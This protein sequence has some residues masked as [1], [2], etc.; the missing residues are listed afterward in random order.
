MKYTSHHILMLT[1]LLLL[2]SLLTTVAHAENYVSGEVIGR[3]TRENSP[4]N[5]TGEINVPDG[6]ELVIEPGVMVRSHRGDPLVVYG[7]LVAIG[8]EQDS[9]HF[10]P[11]GWLPYWGGVRFIEADSGS[12]LSYCVLR[13]GQRNHGAM[14]DTLVSGGNAMLW[15]TD[16]TI[17]HSSFFDGEAGFSGG[18]LAIYGGAAT[19]SNCLFQGNSGYVGG[20]ISCFDSC[21]AIFDSCDF[22]GNTAIWGGGGGF[23]T[24]SST[25]EFSEC[26]WENNAVAP[27]GEGSFGGALFIYNN[28]DPMI[29][30]CS[31]TGNSASRGGAVY[32]RGFGCA[33]RFFWTDFSGNTA[34]EPIGSGGA[35]CVSGGAPVQINYCRFLFNRAFMGGGLYLSDQP[36][37]IVNNALFKTNVATAS[38]GAIC[39]LGNF[40]EYIWEIDRCTFAGNI[41]LAEDV[42]AFHAIQTLS[43]ASISL[44]SC[45]VTG[46]TPFFDPHSTE[47]S[48]CLVRG[49]AEGEGNLD[50]DPMYFDHDVSWCMIQSESPCVD[51]GDASLPNDTDGTRADIGW[52]S[53]PQNALSGVATDTVTVEMIT[54]EEQRI[55]VRVRNRTGIPV[56]ASLKDAMPFELGETVNVSAIT[57]DEE[58]HGAV[59]CDD[60][61]YIS[62]AGNGMNPTIYHL[63]RDF[64][65]VG[66]FTPP[67]N[68]GESGF[69]DLASDGREVLWGGDIDHIVE[70][71]TSGE[72]GEAF[73]CPEGLFDCRALAMDELFSERFTDFYAGDISGTIV[74]CGDDFRTVDSVNVDMN[75]SALAMRRNARSLYAIGENDGRMELVAVVPASGSISQ[76]ASVELA[77]GYLPGGCEVAR[78]LSAS[79]D[80]LVGL[81]RGNSEQD[82]PD[83]LFQA[84]LYP[85]WLG[86]TTETILLKPWQTV[87]WEIT[88]GGED[89]AAGDYA[90]GYQV[91]INGWGDPAERNIRL[92]LAQNSVPEK[93]FAPTDF[94]LSAYPNPFNGQLRMSYILPQSGRVMVNILDTMGR[95]VATV[96]EGIVEPGSHTIGLD[97][98]TLPS[99]KYYARI[100]SSGWS[101][102]IPVTCI[103]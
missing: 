68:P 53:Y 36:R 32:V 15:Q 2:V 97:L 19:I 14:R 74:R 70:F 25:P 75:L 81:L 24:E 56:Y 67:G 77:D 5:I 95:T 101:Q 31:F 37:A 78:G 41:E 52:L 12:V 30:N 21:Q 54:G 1:S 17:D 10:Q 72:F 65:L 23:L 29:L 50:D 71:T 80:K 89:I 87:V 38:G 76:L 9:I 96:D 88:V 66:Q 16:A 102:S 59:W 6:G 90:G 45:I 13:H 40:G 63:D 60:G 83:L 103:K 27:N 28:S 47:I 79:A 22:V 11:V 51:A 100:A 58:L 85:S 46:L 42:N 92:H 69:F 57:G 8:T 7:R 86:L 99:G 73:P 82:L 3:W 4:Y 62:G 98:A 93:S 20:A 55:T 94:A 84:D 91:S 33:P 39:Q 64:Q 34:E 61:Y 48:Y 26:H 43:G 44:S 18:G 35:I 49:G